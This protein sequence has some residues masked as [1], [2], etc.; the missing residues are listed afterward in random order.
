[1]AGAPVT[2]AAPPDPQVVVLFGATGDLAA[3]K[4][5]PGFLRLSEVGLMPSGYRII[6]TSPDSLDRDG[7]VEHV[8][9]AV[10]RFGRVPASGAGWD[11]FAACLEYVPSTSTGMD[12]LAA[13]A[14]AART[15]LGSSCGLVHYLSIPPAAMA[16]I[17]G[18]LGA[19]GLSAD[20]AKV[21]LEKPFGTDLDSAVA[22]NGL[23]HSVFAEEQIF[24]IDHFLGKED[25]QNI[26]AV[27]FSNQLFEPV[28][29]RHHVAQIQIDVPETLGVEDRAAFYEATGAFRDMVVTHLFQALGFVA[30]EPPAAFSAEA[31]AANRQAV[32]DALAPLDPARVARGQYRG[33]RDLPAVADD[34]DTETLVAVEARIDNDRWDGVPVYLRTGK[35]MAEGRRVVTL[36]LREPPLH[37]FPEL[38]G[39]GPDELVFE[40]G[41]PGGIRID[42]LSKAPGPDMVLGPAQLDFDYGRSFD[43]RAELEAYERLL[44]DVMVGDHTLFNTAEGI[45][46]LWTVGAPLLAAPRPV[47]EY[48]PGTW[49]P[50]SV[51]D[52]PPAPGWHLPD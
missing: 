8:R 3:R 12:A 41:E 32:F 10:D 36:T 13:A 4:L 44:H 2:A 34:S 9:D 33:Y 17:V 7:F 51:R 47:E 1:M 39:S 21:V 48:V 26:L 43:P 5:L 30:M 46:R 24:R 27:R 6:G 22:L 11:A 29:N 52:L 37:M 49:G 20:G 28:W 40:I 35:R 31:L 25:V 23:L 16:D 38:D 14:S 50:P 18:G 45:E 19:S 15:A 42:F